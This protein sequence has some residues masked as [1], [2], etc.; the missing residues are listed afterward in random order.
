MVKKTHSIN[1]L[2][3]NFLQT[4]ENDISGKSHPMNFVVNQLHFRTNSNTIVPYLKA[5]AEIHTGHNRFSLNSIVNLPNTLIL[6]LNDSIME[7]S[8]LNIAV[9]ILDESVKARF[10]NYVTPEYTGKQPQAL[11]YATID[12]IRINL[13]TSKV[14]EPQLES[15]NRAVGNYESTGFFSQVD[16]CMDHWGTTEDIQG[17]SETTF[18]LPTTYL[19]FQSVSTPPIIALQFLANTF[20]SV[21]FTLRYKLSPENVWNEVQFYPFPPFG[22]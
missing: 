8:W 5:K 22:Y 4:S 12:K 2:S 17:V 15:L 19:E 21:L 9:P 11:I 7:L 10:L 20:P 14:F 1:T 13:Q 16:W 18:D 3:P 6:P